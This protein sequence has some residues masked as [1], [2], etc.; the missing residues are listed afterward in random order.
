MERGKVLFDYSAKDDRELN[1]KKGAIV[2]VR[3]RRE[4]GWYKATGPNGEKGLIPGNY[5]EL[6]SIRGSSYGGDMSGGSGNGSKKSKRSRVGGGSLRSKGKNG[7]SKKKNSKSKNTIET[8]RSKKNSK[9]K[10]A[11]SK[12]RNSKDS[13]K[14]DQKLFLK[15]GSLLSK[16]SKGSKASK[17]SKRSKAPKPPRRPDFGAL[18]MS[19][20]VLPI[21][22]SANMTVQVN[23]AGTLV[24]KIKAVSDF[25]RLC[26]AASIVAPGLT[27]KLPPLWA[28]KI[29]L[30]F[31]QAI[32]RAAV[33]MSVLE[34]L[35]QAQLTQVLVAH[36]VEG[37]KFLTMD[38]SLQEIKKK[39]VDA[40]LQATAMQTPQIPTNFEIAKV[41]SG[42]SMRVKVRK[43]DIVWVKS[44]SSTKSGWMNV[45][46]SDGALF[47]IERQ[48][49]DYLSSGDKK[50]LQK[51][52]P[53]KPGAFVELI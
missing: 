2:T 11:G 10:K 43:G 29:I 53:S 19:P 15:Q 33:L 20:Q 21:E 24:P 49:L 44:I 3:E 45:E 1:I 36:W 9:G 50:M 41:N 22:N 16:G 5:I 6:F 17:A 4:D 52:R 47:E 42:R 35:T 12:R 48:Y 32:Q 14:K 28:D 39:V 38:G 8:I 46:R 37:T 7:N 40:L 23:V 26:Y 27:F 31:D 51:R 25:R 30:D 18:I 13:K 34:E